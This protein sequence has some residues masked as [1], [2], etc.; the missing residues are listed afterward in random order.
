[1]SV[2]AQGD[3]SRTAFFHSNRLRVFYPGAG[4]RF[5]AR[6]GPARFPGVSSQ[7]FGVRQ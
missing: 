5:A 2:V 7:E 6:I 3:L 4:V 1:M